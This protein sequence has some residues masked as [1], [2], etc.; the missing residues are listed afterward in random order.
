MESFL[1][2]WGLAGFFLGVL[3]MCTIADWDVKR[4]D[5][6]IKHYVYIALT[7]IVGL[8]AVLGLAIILGI[9]YTFQI[10]QTQIVDRLYF[11]GA[12]FTER[13]SLLYR[14]LNYKPFNMDGN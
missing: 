4:K 10:I 14:I 5:Y 8:S 12:G 9:I 3:M 11:D 7:C 6:L 13:E 2:I 1:F